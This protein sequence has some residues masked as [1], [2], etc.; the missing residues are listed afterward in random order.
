MSFVLLLC[1]TQLLGL[2]KLP[3]SSMF[4]AIVNRYL[5][6]VLCWSTTSQSPGDGPPC[7]QLDLILSMCLFVILRYDILNS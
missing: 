7:P 6:A 3:V 2:D 4:M 5:E 1:I